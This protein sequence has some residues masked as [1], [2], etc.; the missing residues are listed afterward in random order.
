M[1]CEKCGTELKEHEQ[2][3]ANCGAKNEY[4]KPVVEE[5]A[6][7]EKE[8]GIFSILALVFVS[9]PAIIFFLL[10]IIFI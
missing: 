6:D 7:E 8:S 1:F 2:V 10:L 5:N 9:V 4:C 3:C